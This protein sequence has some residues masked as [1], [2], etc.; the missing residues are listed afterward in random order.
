MQILQDA[1]LIQQAIA[2]QVELA[3]L[4][5]GH[6]E[7]LKEYEGYEL[8]Q[9]VQFVVMASGETCADLDRALGYPDCA[10]EKI[11]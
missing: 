6:V 7:L 5:T 1:T 9:L 4:I 10:G 2:T 11:R 3:Q 8:S